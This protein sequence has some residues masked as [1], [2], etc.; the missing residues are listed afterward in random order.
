MNLECENVIV[1]F[2]PWKAGNNILFITIYR[3]YVASNEKLSQTKMYIHQLPASYH[4]IFPSQ[5]HC[6]VSRFCSRV[7]NFFPINLNVFIRRKRW[8][9]NSIF[10]KQN[11]HQYALLLSIKINGRDYTQFT[12]RKDQK[13]QMVS[14]LCVGR[15]ILCNWEIYIGCVKLT[16]K[17]MEIES[18]A[19]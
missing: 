18:R 11:L 8:N 9:T 14:M 12:F 1:E 10:F 5:T 7:V 4:N 19:C 17:F 16:E 3:S 13:Y 6:W 15:S 2:F